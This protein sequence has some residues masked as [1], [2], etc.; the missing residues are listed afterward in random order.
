MN[1][2]IEFPLTPRVRS[3]ALLMMA[4]AWLLL[5]QSVMAA[6]S[7]WQRYRIHVP[8]TSN[9]SVPTERVVVDQV[10]QTTGEFPEQS[11]SLQSNSAGGLVADFSVASAFVH[12]DYPS[13]Q[14]DA[15]LRLRIAEQ[16][17]TGQ[18]VTTQSDDQTQQS[19]GDSVAGVQV[20]SN[21]P[22]SAQVALS[23][24]LVDDFAL[25]AP[26]SYSTTVVCTIASP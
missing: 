16:T 11:W 18:W 10:D 21:A 7:A 17:G 3:F 13:I 15:R 5:P 1:A 24:S 25:M 19:A 2:Q 9:V 23:V 14:H 20:R 26:G 12:Q 4:L 6:G 8:V 22:G